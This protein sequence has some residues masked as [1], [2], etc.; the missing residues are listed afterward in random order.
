MKPN[1]QCGNLIAS[2][3]NFVNLNNELEISASL[4]ENRNQ[5]LDF[6][7]QGNDCM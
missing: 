7:D 4:K 3:N 2:L 6:M 1:I 5:S